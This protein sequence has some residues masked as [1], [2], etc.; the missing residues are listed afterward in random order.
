MFRE[1]VRRRLA[2]NCA[3]CGQPVDGR[4]SFHAG[5]VYHPNCFTGRGGP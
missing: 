1:W 3:A 2:P 4:R 5:R